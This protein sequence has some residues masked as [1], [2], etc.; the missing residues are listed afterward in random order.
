[1]KKALVTL[2]LRK[3]SEK[4]VQTAIDWAKAFDAQIILL[5]VELLDSDNKSLDTYSQED[6]EKIM[7]RDENMNKILELEQ[8][9]TE[10][11]IG[12]A[13]VIRFGNPQDVILDVA[14]SENVDLI[15]MGLNKHSAAYKF[16]IGSVADLVVKK[17]DVLVLLIPND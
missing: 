5:H 9:L 11:G 13:R 2:D 6:K 15:F 4:L 1:M 8:R 16:L 12:F 3:D 10:N 14:K 7:M 17:T